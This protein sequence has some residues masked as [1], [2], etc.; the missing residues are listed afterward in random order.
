MPLAL[1][2]NPSD[3]SPRFSLIG[4]QFG[5]LMICLG[6]KFVISPRIIVALGWG[7]RIQTITKMSVIGPLFLG[8]RT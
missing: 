7:G 8:R 5:S 3:G 2:D 6:A 4:Y 1:N